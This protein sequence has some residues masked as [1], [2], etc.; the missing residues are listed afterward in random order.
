MTFRRL[1]CEVKICNNLV[2]RSLVTTAQQ[3]TLVAGR[4][5][6]SWE[7]IEST[8]VTADKEWFSILDVECEAKYDT[9]YEVACR[10]MPE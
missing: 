1:L 8:V 10:I 3:S 9:S 5:E 2:K 7:Y 6:D 4:G